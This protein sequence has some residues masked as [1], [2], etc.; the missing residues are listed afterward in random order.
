MRTS[1]VANGGVAFRLALLD[2]PHH[3]KQHRSC[4]SASPRGT[5][6]IESLVVEQ[7][8]SLALNYFVACAERYAGSS[9][10]LARHAFQ[11]IAAAPLSQ[12]LSA[13]S[14]NSRDVVVGKIVRPAFPLIDENFSSRPSTVKCGNQSD[15]LFRLDT[16]SA[17]QEYFR[18]GSDEPRDAG[19][20]AALGR[21]LH[22]RGA[23]PPR[24]SHPSFRFDPS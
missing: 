19:S 6:G 15:G 22:R 23:S 16:S 11:Y 24:R 8:L 17:D 2:G 9:H 14:Q 21:L 10:A 12:V 1:P 3:K 4:P 13:S 20:L 7:H 5:V 18:T